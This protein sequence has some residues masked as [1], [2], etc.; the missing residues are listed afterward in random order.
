MIHRVSLIDSGLNA[1][2]EETGDEAKN[3]FEENNIKKINLE[4]EVGRN[5]S[6]SGNINS[7]Y[8]F[9]VSLKNIKSKYR[10]KQMVDNLQEKRKLRVFECDENLR[11][12]INID[13]ND[14]EEYCQI[15]IELTPLSTKY[16]KFINIV[17]QED[18]L[19]HIFIYILMIV[20]KK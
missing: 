6:N 5:E 20:M 17:K 14:C 19:N 18:K 11:E 2:T 10:L 9:N 1:I 3:I 12:A 15:E 8:I 4:E 13:I 7:G 16:G